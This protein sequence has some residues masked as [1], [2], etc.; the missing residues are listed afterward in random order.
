MSVK[1]LMTAAHKPLSPQSSVFEAI[2]IMSE[3]CLGA[4]VV[5]QDKK[6]CGIFTYRDLIGRVLLPK[7]SPASASL[8]DVMTKEVKT[9]PVEASYGDALRL[10]VEQDY[11]YLPIVDE[12]ERVIGMLPLRRLLQHHIDA[13]ADELESVTKYFAADGPGG[14]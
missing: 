7:L 10:M 14:D 4:V 9:L 8:Q 11:T 6:P 3:C 5:E 13:L 1:G 2:E 12:Q